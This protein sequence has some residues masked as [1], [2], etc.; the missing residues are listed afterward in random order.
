VTVY[1]ALLAGPTTAAIRLAIFICPRSTDIDNLFLQNT[2]NL[3]AKTDK[4]GQ[5]HRVRQIFSCKIY[6]HQKVPTS[7]SPTAKNKAFIDIRLHPG[8]AMLLVVVG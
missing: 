3:C 4:H 8:I 2:S 1:R 7:K 5:G 6:H